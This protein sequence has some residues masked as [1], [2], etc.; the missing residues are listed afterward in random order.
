MNEDLM[1]TAFGGFPIYF[2]TKKCQR[3]KHHKKRINKKWQK[4]YG[5]SEYD[6]MPYGQV[7]L[8]DGKIYM[9]EKTFRDYLWEKKR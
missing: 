2:A 5:F 4:R 8:I 3:R 6:L 1:S 7:I 9:T